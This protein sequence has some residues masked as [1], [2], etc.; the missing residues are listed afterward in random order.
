MQCLREDLHA[1]EI[2]ACGR[3]YWDSVSP[4]LRAPAHLNRLLVQKLPMVSELL[5]VLSPLGHRTL[6]FI[7]HNTV[8]CPHPACGSSHQHTSVSWWMEG[9][10]WGV[11]ALPLLSQS[12]Q[13]APSVNVPKLPN[14]HEQTRELPQE[15]LAVRAG[16]HAGRP[17]TP[18]SAAQEDGEGLVWHFPRL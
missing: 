8:I 6:T 16:I 7:S 5:T 17:Q 13:R 9:F 18:D 11:S 1:H 15:S 12:H 10:L 3:E 14:A 2:K 4:S